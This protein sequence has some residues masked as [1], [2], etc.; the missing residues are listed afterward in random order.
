MLNLMHKILLLLMF[1]IFSTAT[2]GQTVLQG[3]SLYRGLQVGKSTFEDIKRVMGSGY[4]KGKMIRQFHAKW[5]DG[6]AGT[7]QVI[8]GY[9][10]EYK[11]DGIQFAIKTA[12]KPEDQQTL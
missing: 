10:L 5:R 12:E 11:R 8:Y 9:T 7:Y 3:D 4:K 6:G 2:N 1:A